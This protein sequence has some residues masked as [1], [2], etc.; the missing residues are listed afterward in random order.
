MKL[1]VKIGGSLRRLLAGRH[2]SG[3]LELDLPAGARVSD[4]L[5]AL[6][7]TGSQVRV[8]MVNGRP[9]RDDLALADGD[10]LGLFPAELAF[11]VMTAISFF[12]PLARPKDENR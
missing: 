10:R 5:A 12:N 6:G 1:T 3:L 9:I 2:D 11:N 8:L 7:L 4:V